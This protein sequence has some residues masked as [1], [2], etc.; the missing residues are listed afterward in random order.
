M[1]GIRKSYFLVFFV[2]TSVNIFE[3]LFLFYDF[4]TQKTT[5]KVIT[6]LSKRCGIREI[7][8]HFLK[9]MLIVLRKLWF[10]GFFRDICEY[11]LGNIQ[12]LWCF[13]PEKKLKSVHSFLK[14]V[15][16]CL[17][18]LASFRVYNK[19]PYTIAT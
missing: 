12:F 2:V 10:K 16:H 8:F 9:Y 6:A 5:Q 13:H 11:L 4:G 17:K 19:I 3:V 7:Y 14:W 18:L 15:R 1:C